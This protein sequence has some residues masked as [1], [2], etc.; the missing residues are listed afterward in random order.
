MRLNPV[1]T[2][3]PLPATELP[4]RPRLGFAGVGWIGR[5]RLETV[6]NVIDRLYG[7]LP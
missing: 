5:N 7:R 1:A 4:R 6:A 2:T 3:P